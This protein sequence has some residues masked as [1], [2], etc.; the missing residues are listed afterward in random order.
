ML[1]Q[2]CHSASV[3]CV[4]GGRVLIACLYSILSFTLTLNNLL[5]I[6]LYVTMLHFD[7]IPFLDSSARDQLADFRREDRNGPA[8]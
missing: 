8:M 5:V 6:I 3:A 1:A 2:I 4:V 7:S